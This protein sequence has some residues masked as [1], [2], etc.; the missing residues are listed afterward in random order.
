VEHEDSFIHGRIQE[1]PTPVLIL[2]HV[3]PVHNHDSH[4]LNIQFNIIPS[5]MPR[6]SKRF[7]SLKSLNAKLVEGN[8]IPGTSNT[9]L[10]QIH[11]HS[12]THTTTVDKTA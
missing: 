4:F 11:T 8:V 9:F 2:S 1:H 10:Y 7:P 6:S 12:A 3:N 5:S